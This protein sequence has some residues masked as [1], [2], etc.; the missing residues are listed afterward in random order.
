M[1]FQLV[2]EVEAE[3]SKNIEGGQGERG[4]CMTLVILLLQ[5]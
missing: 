1:L 2:V 5:S 4:R 3:L